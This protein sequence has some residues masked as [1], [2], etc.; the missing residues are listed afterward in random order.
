MTTN[1][2]DGSSDTA[3]SIWGASTKTM[4]DKF[5]ARAALLIED[6][7][8]R[9]FIVSAATLSGMQNILYQ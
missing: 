9:L 2:V 3:D 4:P 1:R 8:I 7:G 6:I 5:R